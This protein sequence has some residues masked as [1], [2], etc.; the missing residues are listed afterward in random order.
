MILDTWTVHYM[1][2]NDVELQE[3]EKSMEME[4]GMPNSGASIPPEALM[5]FLSVSYSPYFLQFVQIPCKIFPILLFPK[6]VLHFHPL[7]FMMTLFSH[8]LHISNFPPIFAVSVH[9]S[10]SEELLFPLIS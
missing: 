2:T 8:W 1:Y 5:H 4:M 7:K 6:N 10:I 9:S 3:M